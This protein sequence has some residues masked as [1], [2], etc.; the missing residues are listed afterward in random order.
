MRMGEP[1]RF[2][3]DTSQ[4]IPRWMMAVWDAVI[5]LIVGI[6]TVGLALQLNPA[7]L[8]F[9][10]LGIVMIS[11][12]HAM[13]RGFRE[14]SRN[15]CELSEDSLRI[16]INRRIKPVTVEFSYSSVERIDQHVRHRFPQGLFGF[17]PFSP[18]SEHVDVGLRRARFLTPVWGGI[19]PWVK[20]LHLQI[21]D[22][23]RFAAVLRERISGTA[24]PDTDGL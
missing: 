14:A 15:F 17:W 5:V 23:E 11:F 7:S 21:V 10:A 8:L 3:L 9:L 20:V 24:V 13:A 6:G 18:W 4:M 16:H 1:Q 2:P 12:M 22:A 19:S